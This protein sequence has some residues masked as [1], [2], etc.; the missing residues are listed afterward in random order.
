MD[1]QIDSGDHVDV[2]RPRVSAL[3]AD[4]AKAFS[5][6]VASQL[7]G[8]RSLIVDLSEIDFIDSAG[9][10]VILSC[11]RRKNADGGTFAL[12]SMSRQVASTFRLVRMDRIIDVFDTRD[13]AVQILGG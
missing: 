3:D 4:N 8:D 1:I 7:Q 10:G 13:D 2:V 9:L 11:L 6:G 5:Q 12:C